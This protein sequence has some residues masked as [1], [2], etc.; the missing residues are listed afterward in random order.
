MN[1]LFFVRFNVNRQPTMITKEN[2]S[3]F[4]SFPAVLSYEA[5]YN[6]TINRYCQIVFAT[7]Y[8]LHLTPRP[9]NADSGLR[10]IFSQF[11]ICIILDLLFKICV[12]EKTVVFVVVKV[13]QKQTMLP[14]FLIKITQ[15]PR[16]A[17]FCYFN[18]I[19]L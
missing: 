15:L 5:P 2:F 6:R 14:Q 13:F 17:G 1:S 7:S 11:T 8:I 12:Y 3:L 9:A 16:I 4:F 18:F 19:V 10:K